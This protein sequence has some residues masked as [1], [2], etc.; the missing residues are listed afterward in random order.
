MDELANLATRELLQQEI[1]TLRAENNSL[2]GQLL[3]SQEHC[4]RLE[5]EAS[6]HLSV[7]WQH[8]EMDDDFKKT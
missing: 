8:D 7:E 4:H 6:L 1:E 5:E 3:E 2:K